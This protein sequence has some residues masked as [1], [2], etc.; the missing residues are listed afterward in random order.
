MS[1]IAELTIP[2]E[3]FALRQT[4]E[5]VDELGIEIERVVA[6]DPD[7]VMP[8]VWF[9]AE[10]T[11]LE[12]IDG[13]LEDDSS[14]EGAELLTDLEDER[15]YRMSWVDDVVVIVH[16][17]TVEQA[18]VLD[19]SVTD[20]QWRFR[21][22]FPER[23]SLSNTYEFASDEGVT[24]DVRKIHQLEDGRHGR[25]GLTDAQYETLVEAL[26]R[27][28]YSIPRE[29]DM[30]GLSDVLGVS[31]QALSERLRRAHRSLVDEVVELEADATDDGSD[32]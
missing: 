7:Q 9:A 6:H 15:L 24:I 22:L 3:E 29:M 28:Y 1:T 26:D 14:V 10:E 27:G 8:Y 4:L 12:R 30:E 20:R 17:L 23:E 18:T 19:A 32:G 21:V 5:A 13:L 11:T 31:H 25:Y 2:A 16:L